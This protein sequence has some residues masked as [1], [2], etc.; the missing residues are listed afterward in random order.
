MMAHAL[1]GALGCRNRGSRFVGL[2]GFLPVSEGVQDHVAFNNVVTET[3]L[4]PAN[5]PLALA[6]PHSNELLDLV[7]L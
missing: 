2:I 7:L 5:P 1:P 6:R 3:L 4:A